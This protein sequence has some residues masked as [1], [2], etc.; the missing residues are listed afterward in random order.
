MR[1]CYTR[2]SE[3]PLLMMIRQILIIVL[4]LLGAVLS[5]LVTWGV[6][7]R[8]EARQAACDTWGKTADIWN[9]QVAG[10]FVLILLF[11]CGLVWE[12][13]ATLYCVRRKFRWTIPGS[14]GA[15]FCFWFVSG[16]CT[17]FSFLLLLGE[18]PDS[19]AEKL[20]L[21]PNREFVCPREMTDKYVVVDSRAE[22]VRELCRLR[23]C[24]PLT[25][26]QESTSAAPA[27]PNVEKL[28]REAPELLHEYV[29]R[30]LYAEALNPRFYSETLKKSGRPYLWHEASPEARRFPIPGDRDRCVSLPA[31]WAWYYD[32]DDWVLLRGDDFVA[33]SP[34]AEAER[35]EKELAPLAQNPTRQ[36]L[37]AMLPPVPGVP[38]LS[39][40]AMRSPDEELVVCYEA[41]LVIPKDFPEGVISLKAR[42]YTQRKPIRFDGIICNTA[43]SSVVSWDM[44]VKSGRKGEFYGSVWEIWFTPA[45]GGE[46]RCVATQEFLLEGD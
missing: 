12:V 25:R 14:W 27:L 2:A 36:Q 11:F 28:T 46:S 6:Y 15:F 21:P 34:G 20:T 1:V 3:I 13:W 4:P 19:F 17:I 42:E 45:D 26:N 32:D 8:T 37:D 31:G 35:L 5:V 40:R 10:I 18:G 7:A 33:Q 30:C 44:C 16:A 9:L 43:E 22:R 23:P 38:F 29:L 24:P 39:L 41:L